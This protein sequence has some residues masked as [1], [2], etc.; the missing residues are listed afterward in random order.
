MGLFQYQRP[1]AYRFENRKDGE[2]SFT[3][4][5]FIK[6]CFNKQKKEKLSRDCNLL[7]QWESLQLFIELMRLSSELQ[8]TTVNKE[9]TQ[10][11]GSGIIFRGK[12]LRAFS[13]CQRWD[14]GHLR[15]VIPVA[16][17]LISIPLQL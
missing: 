5:T 3:T 9:R 10:D 8:Q 17:W 12:I 2:R 4:L 7:P 16:M 6:V 15:Y 14:G 13:W 1:A 11:T